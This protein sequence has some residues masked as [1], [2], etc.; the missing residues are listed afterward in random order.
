[1][2]SRI[3]KQ[4]VLCRTLAGNFV[5]ILTVTNPSRRP[6]DAEVCKITVCKITRHNVFCVRQMMK[7][8][9][10][11]IIGDEVLLD[12]GAKISALI[13]NLTSEITELPWKPFVRLSAK[14]ATKFQ[15]V[16]NEDVRH[17]NA[18]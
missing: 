2:R 16:M 3:C 1:M 4:R 11:N 6:A 17:Y 14:M 12:F 13:N 7:N 9:N 5:Y 8:Y 15:N 18:L 10:H